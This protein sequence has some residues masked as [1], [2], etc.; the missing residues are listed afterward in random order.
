MNSSS[1]AFAAEV[2][3]QSPVQQARV[4]PPGHDVGIGQ[5][6]AQEVDV[7]DDPEH[8]GL[9]QRAVERLSAAARSSAWAI[10]LASI[11]S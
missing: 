5:Q 2:V 7:G 10:T 9:G 6:E 8:R 11:G 1:P 4:E 3:A